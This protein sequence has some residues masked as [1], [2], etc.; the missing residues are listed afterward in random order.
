MVSRMAP[1]SAAIAV[2]TSR[3]SAA[4]SMTASVVR[5]EQFRGL[6]A[7]LVL[8]GGPVCVSR[9][10]RHPRRSARRPDGLR[11]LVPNEFAHDVPPFRNNAVVQFY[12]SPVTSGC[13]V[14]GSRSPAPRAARSRDSRDGSAHGD[15][16]AGHIDGADRALHREPARA[17]RTTPCR[18]RYP[19]WP[20]ACWRSTGGRSARSTATSCASRRSHGHE[21]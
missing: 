18:C 11:N 6:L 17:T 4:S 13:A 16:Q 12:R 3:M 19:T 9:Q 15:V 20:T 7:Q 2:R 8:Q 1:A 5:S 10:G 21:S 14:Q